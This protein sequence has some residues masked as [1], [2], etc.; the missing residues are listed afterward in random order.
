LNNCLRTYN[1]CRDNSPVSV[2]RITAR[3]GRQPG[4]YVCQSRHLRQENRVV[5]DQIGKLTFTQDLSIKTKEIISL[6]PGIYHITNDGVC[7]WYE[8]ASAIMP[9]VKP[10]TTEE[11]QR[12]D[13]RKA[14]RPRYPV[15]SNTKTSPMRHWK[16]ALAE[17]LRMRYSK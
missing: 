7:S 16:E 3:P 8:F 11:Y 1:S 12:V 15:L 4:L 17:Y 6:S 10:C 13:P 2:T 9:N 14:E 5:N